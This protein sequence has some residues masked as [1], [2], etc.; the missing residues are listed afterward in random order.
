MTDENPNIGEE[1]LHLKIEVFR[2]NID[3]AMYFGRPNQRLPGGGIV[4]ITDHAGALDRDENRTALRGAAKSMSGGSA[5]RQLGRAGAK[6]VAAGLF[7]R[8]VPAD[9]VLDY[10]FTTATRHGI[11]A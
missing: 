11:R 9:R 2:V 6:S 3:I 5:C 10:A 4:G 1:V 8:S 7:N